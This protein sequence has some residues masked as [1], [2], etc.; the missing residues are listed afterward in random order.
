MISAMEKGKVSVIVPCYNQA[1]YL[2]ETLDSVLAQTYQNW[3]CVIINDGSPD[4]TESIA[5]EYLGKDKRFKYL[6][7]ENMGLPAARNTGIANSHGEYILPLD[8]DDLIL[9]TYIEKAVNH[10]SQVPETKLVYSRA[11]LFGVQIYEWILP[12]YSFNTLLWKNC[13]FCS[14]IYRRNDYDATDGYNPNM[15]HGLEDWDFWLSLLKKNDIVYQIDEILFRY[16]IKGLSMSTNLAQG[17]VRAMLQQIYL[18]HMDVYEPYVADIISLQNDLDYYKQLYIDL[19][20]SPLEK[21]KRFLSNPV[22]YLTNK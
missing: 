22:R 13:I 12:Q 17:H 10:F 7:Q 20:N 8:A 16:R 6:K 19:K 5:K 9:P 15:K 11:E 18:N 2:P 3:E 4:N 14:A 21:T 1:Q